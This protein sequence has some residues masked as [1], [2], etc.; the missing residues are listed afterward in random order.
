MILTRVVSVEKWGFKL[1]WGGL[2]VRNWGS[3][4][5]N[6][7]EVSCCKGEQKNEA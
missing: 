3:S 6:S 5:D 7:I 2:E 1:D 4:R